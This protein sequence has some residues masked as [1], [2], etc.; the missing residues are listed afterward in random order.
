MSSRNLLFKF[1][2]KLK[3]RTVPLLRDQT[4]MPDSTQ[5]YKTIH[6]KTEYFHASVHKCYN[7]CMP[8][9][10]YDKCGSA[11]DS[12]LL[13]YLSINTPVGSDTNRG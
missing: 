12:Y 5:Y 9:H 6:A 1:K 3:P 4:S 13:P 7:V 10:K 8:F 2:P 11:S